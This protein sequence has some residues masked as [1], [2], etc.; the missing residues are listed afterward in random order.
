MGYGFRTSYQLALGY[1]TRDLAIES[2]GDSTRTPNGYESAGKGI[3]PAF[4]FLYSWCFHSIKKLNL[5]L[6]LLELQLLG[7]DL[8]KKMLLDRLVLKQVLL[9]GQIAL[10]IILL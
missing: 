3:V 8:G 4:E 1:G 2:T 5:Q 7:L 6:N 9:L 10:C